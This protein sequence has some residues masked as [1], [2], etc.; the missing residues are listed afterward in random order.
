MFQILC[1]DSATGWTASQRASHLPMCRRG[2]AP[3]PCALDVDLVL[4]ETSY[5]RHG[6]VKPHT[7][8]SLFL[9]SRVTNSRS[10]LHSSSI[11]HPAACLQR[12][13]LSARSRFRLGEL[14]VASP[15][16]AR[17]MPA[18]QCTDLGLPGFPHAIEDNS[19]TPLITISPAASTAV[20]VTCVCGRLCNVRQ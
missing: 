6:T 12:S 7:S 10:S 17:P 20:A 18:I 4:R 13:A 16:R 3:T 11:F 14:P 2:S 1:L 19:S 5:I 8:R 9:P 15:R